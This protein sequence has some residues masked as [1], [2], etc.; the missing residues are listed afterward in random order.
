MEE[1]HELI[2]TCTLYPTTPGDPP[3]PQLHLLHVS[4]QQVS[5]KKKGQ[6]TIIY[7]TSTSQMLQ[8]RWCHPSFN[9]P[10]PSPGCES[11][12]RHTLSSQTFSETLVLMGFNFT[13]MLSGESSSGEM[14]DGL[15]GLRGLQLSRHGL[16]RPYPMK[17]YSM[18]INMARGCSSVTTDPHA[19]T[20]TSA[21]YL[22]SSFVVMWR[23]SEWKGEF[24]P[25]KISV[26]HCSFFKDSVKSCLPFM[27]WRNLQTLVPCLSSS[28][29][30]QACTI[31][32]SGT[33]ELPRTSLLKYRW[34]KHSLIKPH[35]P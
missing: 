13:P 33:C 35:M 24:S 15:S 20:S 30:L 26:L 10:G 23:A 14:H 19:W 5:Q 25:T 28:R 34:S 17:K 21:L 4:D 9:L 8:L 27:D 1:S 18:G 12:Q 6:K 16:Y 32:E 22:L 11:V 3:S 7:G 29:L 31:S 2:S